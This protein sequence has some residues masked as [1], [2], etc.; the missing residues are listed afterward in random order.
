MDSS[1]TEISLNNSALVEMSKEDERRHERRKLM[2]LRADVRLPGSTLLE[3]NMV[4][5][6]RR[7][8]GILAPIKLELGQQCTISVDLSACGTQM[9]LRLVG[10][11]C[12]CMP[13]GEDFRVGLQFVQMDE[14]TALLIEDLLK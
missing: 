7:G 12:Y 11:V 13:S 14:S 4:D 2:R 8:A 1:I 9:A 6:S 3:G 10:R 5:L